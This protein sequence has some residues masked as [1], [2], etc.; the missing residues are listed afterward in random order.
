MEAKHSPEA[1]RHMMV[2]MQAGT[3]GQGRPACIRAS[4][5]FWPPGGFPGENHLGSRR[6]AQ[7]RAGHLL[8][9]RARLARADCPRRGGFTRNEMRAHGVFPAMGTPPRFCL[10]CG[11]RACANPTNV[12]FAAFSRPLSRCFQVLDRPAVLGLWCADETS[13]TQGTICVLPCTCR[14]CAEKMQGK[15]DVQMGA[16]RICKLSCCQDVIA[17]LSQEKY[18]YLYASCCPR[19]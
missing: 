2:L 12:L 15:V 7:V 6:E 18:L 1:K 8:L 3:S 16:T 11:C 14:L 5:A 19:C 17:P 10:E 4:C 13:S 9:E